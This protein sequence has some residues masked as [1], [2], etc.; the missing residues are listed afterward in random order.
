MPTILLLYYASEVN[1]TFSYQMGW[2]KHLLA[3][4][5]FKYTAI[6]VA[7]SVSRRVLDRLHWPFTQY[8]SILKQSYDGVI[9]LHSAFSNSCYLRGALFER[10]RRISAPKAYFVG[11]EYKH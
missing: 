3:D 10:V 5:R 2:P 6:N 1:S 4:K 9:I 7:R 8:D 11:N